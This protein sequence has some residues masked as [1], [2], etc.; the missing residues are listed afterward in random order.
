MTHEELTIHVYVLEERLARLAAALVVLLDAI[1][2]GNA[3]KVAREIWE[4]LQRD[5][6]P[7]Q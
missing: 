7:P 1:D 5:L 4:T 2:D 6:E 3:N